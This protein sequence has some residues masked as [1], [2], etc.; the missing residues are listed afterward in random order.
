[1]ST[2]QWIEKLR[3]LVDAGLLPGLADPAALHHF[4]E[5]VEQSLI[6]H[7][8][9]RA[10]ENLPKAVRGHGPEFEPFAEIKRI[11]NDDWHEA[12]WLAALTTAVGWDR[13][14]S[15]GQLY[16]ALYQGEPWTWGRVARDGGDGMARWVDANAET[17]HRAAPFGDHRA[18]QSHRATSPTST[19]R[20]LRSL[21]TWLCAHGDEL[22]PR[23]ADFGGLYDAMEP[24]TGFGRTGR[25]DFLR[26]LG[27]LGLAPLEPALC[28]FLGA[29]GPARGARQF[30]GMPAENCDEMEARA[31]DVEAA[32]GLPPMIVEDVLCQASKGQ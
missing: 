24:V 30:F 23:S 2:T 28:Y 8:A 9:V 11:A 6:D 21:V 25:Y 22:H 7:A 16:N 3:P 5:A 1:M 29:S 10:G 31:R 26:L 27:L 18:Y 20:V 4:A 15:V 17:L 13:P 19:G 32:L 12:A 14:E